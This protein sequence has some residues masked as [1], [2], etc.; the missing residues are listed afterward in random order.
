MASWVSDRRGFP[1]GRRRALRRL[2]GQWRTGDVSW[3]QTEHRNITFLRDIDSANAL[4]LGSSCVITDD[5]FY[6]HV[7]D[8]RR[9]REGRCGDFSIRRHGDVISASVRNDDCVVNGPGDRCFM[10]GF[11]PIFRRRGR[12]VCAISPKKWLNAVDSTAGEYPWAP[13]GCSFCREASRVRS[14]SV[15]ILRR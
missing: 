10:R 9:K 4:P 3:R 11:D 14:W 7:Y 1:A 13:F 8:F 6:E 5:V 2:L 12:H 15:W